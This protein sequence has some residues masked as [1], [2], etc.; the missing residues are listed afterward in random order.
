MVDEKQK[1]IRDFVDNYFLARDS[2]AFRDHIRYTQPDVNLYYT[3]D[4]ERR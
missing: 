4:Q 3:L 2:R 1:H